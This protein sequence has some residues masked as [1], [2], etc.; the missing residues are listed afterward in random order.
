[1]KLR[2]MQKFTK[3]V[4]VIMLTIMVCLVVG[5]KK[6]NG[7]NGTCNGYDYVDFSWN[8]GDWIDHDIYDYGREF[9]LCIR[10]SRMWS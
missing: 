5:C 4:A 10:R 9:D 7:G 8:G 2:L 3:P 1:M 6:N